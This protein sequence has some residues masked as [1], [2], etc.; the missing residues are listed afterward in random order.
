MAKCREHFG[1][2]EGG[3]ATGKEKKG[4][5]KILNSRRLLRGGVNKENSVDGNCEMVWDLGG[6]RLGKGRNQKNQ[7]EG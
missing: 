5:E 2:S 3:P 7:E 6:P 4:G 1:R